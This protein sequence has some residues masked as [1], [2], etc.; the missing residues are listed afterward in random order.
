MCLILAAVVA[1]GGDSTG[2][3]A[4]AASVTGFAGDSQQAP[5]GGAFQYPLSF[6]TL[7][8]DGQPIADVHVSWTVTPAG[9]ATFTPQTSVSDVNG[10]VTTTVTAGPTVQ[11]FT[12]HANV[13]GV[14]SPVVFSGLVLDPCTYVRGIAVGDLVNGNLSAADCHYLGNSWFYDFYSL[15]L[16]VGQQ[17]VRITM[18]STAFDTWIDLLR[19][20]STLA[21]FDDDVVLTQNQNSQL[22]IIFPGDVYLIGAN[23][24]DPG[25]TGNYQLQVQSRPAAMNGCREVWVLGGVSVNDSITTA[26]CSDTTASVSRFDVARMYLTAGTV[27]TLTERSG[28]IDPMLGLYRITGSAGD[29][30]T[31]ALVASN[32]DSTTGN[33]TAFILDTIAISGPYDVV[34]G[35]NAAG[36]TG[37]YTFDVSATPA[38]S[39]PMPVVGARSVRDRLGFLKR[40][41][42]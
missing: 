41:K 13:P 32:D 7:G 1:C 28:A 35:G 36:Q 33:P 15:G 27:V 17:S 3:G 12:V 34:I 2:P 6:V 8:S 18:Q 10:Q 26:D 20:D 25:A 23:S 29:H 5:T 14:T 4:R 16:P 30:Y 21:G 11:P 40:S 22:D 42:H 24:Y 38:P 39:A 37:A 19:T 31:H 9:A